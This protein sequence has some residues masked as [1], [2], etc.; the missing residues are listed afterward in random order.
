MIAN[1]CNIP[2]GSVKRLPNFFDR[3]MCFIMKT[4]NFSED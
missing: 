4:Y 3:S 2:I 1:F